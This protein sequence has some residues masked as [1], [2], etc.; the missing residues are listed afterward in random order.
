VEFSVPVVS[1]GLNSIT[2]V[3]P[4][5]VSGIGTTTVTWTFNPLTLGTFATSLVNAGANALQDVAGHSLANPFNQ[6]IKVLTGDVN[7]D[8]VVNSPDVVLVNNAIPAAYSLIYDI[9][10]DGVV[11][12]AD[13][14]L[15]R[16]KLNNKL[17]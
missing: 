2:G 4:T 3:T 5:A 7:D 12:A 8:G 1:G 13:V 17:P 6:T 10:G 9:N 16:G 11:N 15:V 14:T